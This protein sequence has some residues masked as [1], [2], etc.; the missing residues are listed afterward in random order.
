MRLALSWG[1]E[2]LPFVF[3][4]TLYRAIPFPRLIF[5]MGFRKKDDGY[6][7]HET[8]I[9]AV[10]ERGRLA[11]DT[12]LFR[13]PYSHVDWNTRMCIGINQFPTIK[14]LD[15]AYKMPRYVLT[16][17]NLDHYYDR[18]TNLSGMVLRELLENLDGKES[19]PEEW[20]SPL[21]YT[22]EEWVVG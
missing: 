12:P 13:Y 2:V 4:N 15:E 22:L 18:G 6:I 21:F 1:P 9:V 3:E 11:K 16:I 20:L 14:T 10:K 8:Y 17:P 7:L 19:F 5:K